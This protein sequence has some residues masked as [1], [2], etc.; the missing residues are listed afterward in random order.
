MIVEIGLPS[1][2]KIV[3]MTKIL[4]LYILLIVLVVI[5][6]LLSFL[7]TRSRH[8]IVIPVSDRTTTPEVTSLQHIEPTVQ[9]ES[10]TLFGQLI[11]QVYLFLSPHY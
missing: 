7:A 10:M 8:I 4:V 3:P 2:I 6:I 9:E 5:N 11:H 1:V